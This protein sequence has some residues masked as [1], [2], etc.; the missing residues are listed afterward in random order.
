MS[1][2]EVVFLLD[3]YILFEKYLQVLNDVGERHINRARK[4]I[5]NDGISSVALAHID[6]SVF[7]TLK[8]VFKDWDRVEA[9]AKEDYDADTLYLVGL[10]KRSFGCFYDYRQDWS[11]NRLKAICEKEGVPIPEE[12]MV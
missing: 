8:L 1:A 12:E 2:E 9:L 7:V 6:P 5:L 4:I 10:L 11:V 3:E